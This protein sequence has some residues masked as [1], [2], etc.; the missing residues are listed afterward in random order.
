MTSLLSIELTKTYR[1]LRTYIGFGVIAVVIP[2]IYLGMS[3]GGENMVN[4]MTR[5]LQQDFVFVGNLFNGWFV[6]NMVMNSLWVHIPFL[7]ALVAGD[8]FA[9]E[10][11]GGTFR[12]L[13]TRPPS[14]TRIFTVK[15]TA[16]IIYTY[17]LVIFLGVLSIGLGLLLFGTGDLLMFDNGLI[18]LRGDD[19]L[20]RFVFAYFLAGIA[21]VTVASLAL[22]L[23][24]FVENA[25][26]PI[27]GTMA[28][29]I[30]FFIFGNLDFSFFKT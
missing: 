22:M 12:I 4:S 27:I 20:W 26:G 21:M 14:R 28:V 17:S 15:L 10:A 9:G 3:Y 19:V 7:I 6:A 30:A 8:M 23:S 16:T 13:L 24:T 1:K 18:I 11:T 2:L 29:V 5:N 25:I